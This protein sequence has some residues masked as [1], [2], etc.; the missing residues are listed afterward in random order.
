MIIGK[1]N[2]FNNNFNKHFNEI[3]TPSKTNN[4]TPSNMNEIH[5]LTNANNKNDMLDKSFAMLQ[6]RYN[7]GVISLEEFTKQCN[8]INKLRQK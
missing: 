5:N 6:E 8:K 1:N 7:S 3:K 4:Q 2:N